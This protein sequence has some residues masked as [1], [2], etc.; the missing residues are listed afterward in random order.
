MMIAWMADLFKLEA[1][2]HC[3]YSL[4]AK[5][6]A[7]SLGSSWWISCIYGPSSNSGKEEFG[8]EWND[9][10]NLTEGSMCIGGD[11]NEVLHSEDRNGRRSPCVQ[12]TKFHEWVTDFALIDH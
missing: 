9:L 11:F 5:L 8:I 10:G 12:R 7:Y 6:L 1:I 2:E 4:S 3:T